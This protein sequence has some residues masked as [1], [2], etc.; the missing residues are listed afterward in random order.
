MFVGPDSIVEASGSV[1][2]SM[3]AVSPRVALDL[4]NRHAAVVVLR[5]AVV[6]VVVVPEMWRG[7]L[8]TYCLWSY[9]GLLIL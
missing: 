7:T 1:S 2:L 5:A 3:A 4:Y 9:V 6:V 8:Y